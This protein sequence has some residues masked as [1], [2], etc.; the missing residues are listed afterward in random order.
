MKRRIVWPVL[1]I[2]VFALSRWPNLMPPCFSAAYA[3][4]FCA[5]LYL[6]GRTGWV[7]PL[8]VL[9]GS[10]LL[11]TLIFYR[12]YGFS[13][14]EFVLNM[15][16]GWL[17]Y[18][19]LIALGRAFGPKR[20][21]WM[22]TEGGLIGAVLFYIV[23]NTSSWLS[24]SYAKTLAGWV[25]ALTIGLPNHPPTWEF[26]RNTLLS[27]GLFTGLFVG[28]MKLTEAPEAAEEKEEPVGDPDTEPAKAEMKS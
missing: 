22:L 9:A 25:Q 11:I 6:P 5:G 23:T 14:G 21:L 7:I 12:Q 24:L 2:V 10:D 16:P 15:A 20:P 27:G 3:I 8:C 18:A 28:A 17:V 1:L 19:G 4:A 26:F 13:A